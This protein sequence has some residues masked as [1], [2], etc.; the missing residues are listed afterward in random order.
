MKTIYSKQYKL[1]A[2][3]EKDLGGGVISLDFAAAEAWAR[4]AAW[5]ELVFAKEDAQRALDAMPNGPKAG[6]YQDEVHVYAG[7]MKK[8]E[9]DVEMT[10]RMDPPEARPELHPNAWRNACMKT[11][12]S[13]QYKDAQEK[14][15][16]EYVPL[17]AKMRDFAMGIRRFSATAS[18]EDIIEW[19]DMI[20]QYAG[21]VEMLEKRGGGEARETDP[22]RTGEPNHWSNPNAVGT[23]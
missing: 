11:I 4:A 15:A 20:E 14:F 16:P 13:K 21:E 8:R 12:Y 2:K 10:D 18:M 5:D 23:M 17:S 3:F 1:A 7:E 6:F 19:A 9:D 22:T